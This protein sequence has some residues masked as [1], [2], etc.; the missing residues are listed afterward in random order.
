MN[1]GE[2][3]EE[4]DENGSD[5]NKFDIIEGY[6]YELVDIENYIKKLPKFGAPKGLWK[7]YGTI[8]SELVKYL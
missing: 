1:Y 4:T 5:F 8:K 7:D 2:Y 6:E 3:W